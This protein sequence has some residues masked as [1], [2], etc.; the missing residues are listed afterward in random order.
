MI[1][2]APCSKVVQ[3]LPV[4]QHCLQLLWRLVATRT[5]SMVAQVLPVHQHC[6]Q[7]LWHMIATTP[8][9]MVARRSSCQQHRQ[10]N[11]K[12]LTEYRQAEL[13]RRHRRHRMRFTVCSATLV[14]HS[15]AH[16]KSTQPIIRLIRWYDDTFGYS[17]SAQHCRL[18][19]Y[20][21]LGEP[22]RHRNRG[23]P[24]DAV[25]V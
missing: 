22:L 10:E 6:L 13:V 25:G 7:L 9:S 14:A 15:Q 5:C 20:C 19:I 3:V 8:C 1:A 21:I 24:F 18:S 2:T 11:I 4:H 12:H 17:I 16:P 23:K